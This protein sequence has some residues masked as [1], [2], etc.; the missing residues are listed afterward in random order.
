M[1]LPVPLPLRRLTAGVALVALPL[2]ATAACGGSPSSDAGATPSS[3]SAGQAGGS[4]PEQALQKASDNL[5]ASESMQVSLRLEDPQGSLKRAATSGTDA[6]TPEQADLLLGGSLTFV[7]D[8]ADGKTLREVQTAGADLSP[9]EQLRLTNIAFSVRADGGD[10][11]QVRLVQGD[12]YANVGLDAVADVARQ[13][14]STEDVAAQIEQFEAQAPPELQPL[15]ADV[16]AGKWVKVPLAPYVDQ[17]A[18]LGGQAQPSPSVDPQKVGTDLLNA[19]RPFITVEDESQDGGERVLDVKVQ[20][21]QALKAAV[22]TLKAMGPALP[23]LGTADLSQ[24]DQLG[25]GTVDGTVVLEDDHLTRVSVDLASAAALAPAG[26]E[27]TPDLAGG[28]VTM[29][30]DDSADE[31]QVPTD[32]SSFDVTPLLQ[33]AFAGLMGGGQLPS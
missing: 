9:A 18:A 26:G 6:G 2:G 11:F 16:R 12:L 25:D 7:V 24:L 30:V 13:G 28:L 21:K 31:V 14:G 23:G 27:P 32:V 29:D 1:P 5:G 15:V 4:S 22:E 19:I 3:S 33:Q 10:L 17:L 20:A 8:P